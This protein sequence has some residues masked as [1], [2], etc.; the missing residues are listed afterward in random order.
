MQRGDKVRVKIL[1][2]LADKK[3]ISLGLK[4]TQEDPWAAAARK[5]PVGTVVQV[6]VLRNTKVGVFVQLEPGVEGLIHISQLEKKGNETPE[7]PLDAVVEAKVI[8]ASLA[9]RKIGLSIRE[10][11][12][13]L[14]SAEVK[15]YLNT[16][17]RGAALSE[18]SGGE[19]LQ[20]LL[21][22]MNDGSRP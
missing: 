16:N 1:E 11:A 5:Y 20:E 18:L 22:R 19:K 7:L 15:K 9:D 6:K 3:K 8:K 4:Q 14:E 10:L 12:S 2:F 17:K 21:Q 13:D